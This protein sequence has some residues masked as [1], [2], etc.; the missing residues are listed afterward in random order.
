MVITSFLQAHRVLLRTRKIRKVNALHR[1]KVSKLTR[2]YSERKR[3]QNVIGMLHS[4]IASH[5]NG[6]IFHNPIKPSDAP[7]YY[8]I[9]KR[10]MDLKTIKGRV[11]EGQTSSSSEYTRD[12]FLMFANSLMY[13]R[14]TTDIYEMAEEVGH[15]P[16]SS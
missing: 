6:T 1:D 12:I 8:E 2:L 13:N 15:S 14:P 5:R 7:D 4:Q 9:V 3:F 11:R 16:C 10:P